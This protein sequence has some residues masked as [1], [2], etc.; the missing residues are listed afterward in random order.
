MGIT[1]VVNLILMES[2]IAW[3]KDLYS[4]MNSDKIIGYIDGEQ[5]GDLEAM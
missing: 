3:I 1:Q 5:D 4:L 2:K